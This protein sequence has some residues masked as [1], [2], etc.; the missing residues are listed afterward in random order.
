MT[1]LYL[2]IKLFEP[3]QPKVNDLVK[4][5]K[6]CFVAENIVMMEESILR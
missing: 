5:S 1:T 2:A 6:G 3:R 4:L